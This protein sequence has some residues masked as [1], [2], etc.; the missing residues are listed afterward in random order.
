[1]IELVTKGG[2]K[3][4]ELSDDLQHS[5]SLVIK[6]KKANLEDVYSSE[7]LVKTFNNQVKELKDVGTDN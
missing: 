7:D 2:R 4:G 6:G 1:M 3:I 5:D